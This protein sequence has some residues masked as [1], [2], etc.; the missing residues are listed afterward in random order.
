MSTAQDRVIT[1][2]VAVNSGTPPKL[3]FNKQ[4]QQRL[5]PGIASTANR[6]LGWRQEE[7]ASLAWVNT[8]QQQ[9]CVSH[10]RPGLHT[11]HSRTHTTIQI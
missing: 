10:T 4:T 6:L 8:G 9:G 1:Y 5:L 3:L 2:K 11:K 7:W